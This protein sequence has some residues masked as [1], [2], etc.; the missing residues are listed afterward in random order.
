M[1]SINCIGADFGASNGRIF[2]GRFDGTV[3]ELCEVHRFENNPVRLGK[4]L[5]WDFLYLFNNL[6]IGIY[7]AKKQFGTIDSIGVD[8]WGVDYGLVDKYGNL[9]SN[10]YH[11]RDLRTKSAIEEVGNIIP[12]NQLYNTTGIQFMN[13]NTIFQ[14]YIDYKTRPEIMKNAS[15]LLF[16]P[17][18]FA[19]F[20]T[21]EKVNEYTIAS[22][23]QLLD[24]HKRTWSFEIIEKLGFEKDLFNDIIYPGNT[25]GKLSKEIQEELEIENI[26]VIAVGSHDT[27][28][29]V[30]AAPFS[31]GKQ[32]VYLSCGTWSL[33]GVELD[34]PLINEKTFEKNFTNEGGVENKIRFLKNITGLWIIQQLKSAWSKKFEEVSYN[35]ISELAQKS[36]VDYAIDPDSQEFLAPVDIIS[37]I[38]NFCKAH[39]EKEPQTLGDIAKAAYNGIVKKYQNTVEEIEKLTGLKISAI[40]MV[41]GGIRDKYFCE[42]TAKFTKRDVVAGPVEATVLGNILMQL[43][44]LGEIKNLQEGRELLKKS[45]QF[46]YYKGR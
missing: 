45:V 6:K 11:Y 27:A 39:F 30:A 18:L 34:S 25:L 13:F 38:K 9:I 36:D 37:E 1:K 14:L 7:K 41:G 33:M 29:A 22:T 28:S 26:P 46:E 8:T 40:N 16:I 3:L 17:D 23:S 44:A 12:L 4:S 24:A 31:D 5:Y 10:P 42:L 35:L 19:Y 43:I 15:S 21:G 20:L 2:V 32:T